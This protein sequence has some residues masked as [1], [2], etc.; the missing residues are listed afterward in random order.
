MPKVASYTVIRDTDLTLPDN[1]DIDFDL[2]EFG[3][4]DLTSSNAGV[5]RPI[6]S[7]KVNALVDDAR[8]ELYLNA[9]DEDDPATFAQTYAAGTIRTI[10]EVLSHDDVSE[11]NNSLRVK[12]TGTGT[13]VLSDVVLHYKADV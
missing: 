8:V 10:T 13:F 6:L 5:D 1:G 2:P 3:L 12:R 7:F 11:T 9:E 4:P